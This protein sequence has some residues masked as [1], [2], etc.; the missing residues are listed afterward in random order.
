MGLPGPEG[1]RLRAQAGG[2]GEE[3]VRGPAWQT[4]TMLVLLC[5][6]DCASPSLLLGGVVWEVE[7]LSQWRGTCISWGLSRP[8]PTEGPV[9]PRSL[10]PAN[11]YYYS[12]H[13]WPVSRKHGS[14]SLL[15]KRLGS[16]EQALGPWICLDGNF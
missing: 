7:I 16:G 5:K 2:M 10:V 14:F 11:P 1:V 12:D 4:W 13:E 8:V 15:V 9:A 3:T 6:A